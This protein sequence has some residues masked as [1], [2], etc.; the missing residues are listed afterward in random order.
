MATMSIPSKAFGAPRRNARGSGLLAALS[1][2]FRAAQAREIDSYVQDYAG[3]R[4]CDATER[5][6]SNRVIFGDQRPLI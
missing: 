3:G 6:A 4:W 5:E 1:K 2:H